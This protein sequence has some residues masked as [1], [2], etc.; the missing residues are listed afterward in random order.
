MAE[1]KKQVNFPRGQLSE[2]I[3]RS[4][5]PVQ[6]EEPD[7]TS[8]LFAKHK[9]IFIE[10][11]CVKNVRVGSLMVG[12]VQEI[13]DYEI[14]LVL[15]GGVYCVIPIVHISP[16]YTQSLQDFAADPL[17]QKRPLK[18]N[19][20]FY[21]GQQLTVKVLEKRNEDVVINDGFVSY[22][23][24]IGT[25]NPIELYEDINS[26]I[27]LKCCRHFIVTACVRSVEDHGY[28]MD[29]GV[30]GLRGF[31][32]KN[33][34]KQ[35]VKLLNISTLAV[36]QVITCLITGSVNGV[37]QL[38]SDPNQ[39][40]QTYLSNDIRGHFP[41]TCILPGLNVKVKVVDIQ[42]N[43]LEV[44]M[45]DEFPGYILKSHLKTVWDVTHINYQIDEEL[46][47][48][49]LFQH[50]NTKHVVLSLRNNFDSKSP[51]H[52]W[53]I[54]IGQKFPKATVIACDKKGTVSFKLSG[55]IKGIAPI[56]EL[57]D[58]YIAP[59]DV[60]SVV[61]MLPLNS[62][63][64]VRVKAYS[65]IDGYAKVT[66]K[67][68]LVDIK[69][70]SI[71]DMQ[72]G[73]FVTGKVKELTSKGLI[74]RVGFADRAFV[75]LMHLTEST[76]VK[77]LEKLFPMDKE[78]T[79]RVFRID[80]VHKPPRVSLTLKKSLMSNSTFILDS[81]DKVQ[82]DLQT[83]GVICLIK[84]DG[85]LL[86][87]FNRLRAWVS[88]VHVLNRDLSVYRIGQVVRCTIIRADVDKLKIYASLINSS[89]GVSNASD[90]KQSKLTTNSNDLKNFDWNE[91]DAG[92]KSRKR[93]RT[94]SE[95]SEGDSEAVAEK[96]N[97]L[98]K[99]V[100]K[101][102]RNESSAE[103]RSNGTENGETNAFQ[104]NDSG[105]DWS[106]NPM[107]GLDSIGFF[108]QDSELGQTKQSSNA[109]GA[110]ADKRKPRSG[111]EKEEYLRAKENDLMDTY[112]E[113]ESS[114][115]FERLV[116]SSP[117]SSMVWVRYMSFWLEK[118]QID[119][120]R[121]IGER[122]LTTIAYREEGEKLNIWAAL[123]NIEISFG[124]E[125]MLQITY[126]RAQKMCDEY[127]IFK[128]LV[129]VL[130]KDEKTDKALETFAL[131]VR[132]LKQGKQFWID[133]GMLLYKLNKIDQGRRVLEQSLK[134]L[135]KAD[136]LDVI[137]KFAQL[138]FKSGE[139][140][141]GKS[142]FENLLATYPKRNDLWSVYLD[143]MIKYS[144]TDEDNAACL[145]SIRNI[146]ERY[147]SLK[148]KSNRLAIAYKKYVDFETKYGNKTSVDRVK[149]KMKEALASK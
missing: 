98:V 77:N 6:E 140:E 29:F 114:D 18:L 72:L 118:E 43:G 86:E 57:T 110:D 106:F 132:K 66:L 2:T 94:V 107:S 102:P 33:A 32:P 113:P 101:Q 85:L 45:F 13:Y 115:D 11:I 31:L 27:F 138:E 10:Q 92:I 42:D 22:V 24:V 53:Q 105:F 104:S 112:H 64:A 91:A 124:N 79:G 36:G 84:D 15:P 131:H 38:T 25:V 137:S 63:Q 37:V 60:A 35:I 28:I 108:H 74:L 111:R 125:E 89:V 144:R 88:K 73:S 9:K 103:T 4:A 48:T 123:L 61:S 34:S 87:F 5:K 139:T 46:N 67:S 142:L 58:D 49:V 130:V 135:D 93:S 68:S 109:S 56:N 52:T 116:I 7:E 143:V 141:R 75:P 81:F 55:N 51:N 44:L 20:M 136:H 62:K 78:V 126:R 148:L 133:Y 90:A 71:E 41:S 40:F 19:S 1:S 39:L 120:A 50:P 82:T 59:D 95:L 3:K 26:A 127:S 122:A 145:L 147:I 54:R 128:V 149:E 14:K 100:T 134:S 83:D 69:E 129:E 119:K 70:A 16:Y 96:L 76:M 8:P 17:N 146:F 23:Q 80:R 21:I 99:K 117:N 65:L 97:S 121:Q 30:R 47:A 12:C